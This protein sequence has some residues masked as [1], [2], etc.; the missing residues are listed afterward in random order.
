MQG[1]S[2][3]R[4][5]FLMLAGV[6]LLYLGWKLLSGFLSGETTNP[7]FL[8]SA[9]LFFIVGV[10]II[11]SNIRQIIKMSNEESKAN[12]ENS[13]AEA[14]DVESTD[15]KGAN[16]PEALEKAAADTASLEGMKVKNDKKK[17]KS[18]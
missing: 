12:A 7:V 16:T 3:G 4:Y 14:T 9:V 15:A 18:F 2:K 1:T 6:Y 13:D 10:L 11:I 8:I 5:T 17:K